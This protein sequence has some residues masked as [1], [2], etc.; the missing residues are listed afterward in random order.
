MSTDHINHL[1][2][3]SFFYWFINLV[4]RSKNFKPKVE[5]AHYQIS[6]GEDIGST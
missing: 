4:N 3:R 2:I 1:D 5:I 6:K